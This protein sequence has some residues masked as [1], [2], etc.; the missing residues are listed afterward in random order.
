M[1]TPDDGTRHSYDYNIVTTRDEVITFSV[2]A[3]NDAHILLQSVPGSIDAKCFE[4]V[5]GAYDNTRSDIR[6]GFWVRQATC[7]FSFHRLSVVNSWCNFLTVYVHI[8][9]VFRVALQAL[10]M[11]CLM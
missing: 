2:Q 8:G 7:L 6:E 9:P 5:L 10:V 4:I 11:R 1:H 3:C